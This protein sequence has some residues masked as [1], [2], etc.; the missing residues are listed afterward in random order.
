[1]QNVTQNLDHK[2][3]E[4]VDLFCGVGGLTHGFV[5]ED[6]V[7]KAGIDFDKSCRFAYEE[8]NQA[9]F[10]H[11]DITVF[12]GD[13][14]VKLYSKGKRKILVGCAPCQPFSIYKNANKNRSPK[15]GGE[16]DNSVADEKW[17]LLYSFADL[18]DE[19]EPEIVSMENVPLLV[20]F[21]GGKVFN[22]FVNRLKNRGY[23]V[24]WKVVNAQDYGVPQRRKR[25]LLFGSKFGAVKLVPKTVRDGEYTTVKD[26]IGHLPWVEDGVAH[27]DDGLHKARKLSEINKRRIKATKEGGFWRDWDQ[28]LWLECHKKESGKAFRSVYGRMKWDDVAPTM[29]TCCNGLGNGRFGHPEQDRAITLREAALLQ[30]FPQTY[31]FLDPNEKFSAPT[32]AR[33]IGNAVPVGLGVAIAKTIKNHIQEFDN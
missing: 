21:N 25:L 33:Q 5:K 18:I 14:L 20:K 1:M 4:V 27:P 26:A 17:K 19:V 22:D 10:L 32:L 7:V 15:A 24:T 30:S 13:E 31:K 6:F 9:E 23:V 28:S 2:N 11:K 16:D 8:N 29:T 12:T 3:F